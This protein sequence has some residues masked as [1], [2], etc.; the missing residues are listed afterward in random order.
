MTRAARSSVRRPKYADGVEDTAPPADW[1]ACQEDPLPLAEAMDWAVLPGCGAV[2]S[3]VGTVRDHAEGRT[4][5]VS[6]HYE[7]YREQ[8]EPKL[9]EVAAAARRRWPGLGRVA[10]V[11]RIGTLAVGE[12]SVLVVVS[13]PHRAEAFDAARFCID[14]VK[15]AVPIWKHETWDGGTDWGL[16]AQPV[17]PADAPVGQVP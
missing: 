17:T 6:V 1:V 13:A 2:T 10:L 8:V 3:F 9:A 11:H 14:T 15:T 16:G 12:A 5:V 4:G 7:A